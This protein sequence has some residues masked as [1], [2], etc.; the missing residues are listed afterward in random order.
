MHPLEPTDAV[1]PP[2]L[3]VLSR[4]AGSGV[5]IQAATLYLASLAPGA[6]RE[7][8]RAALNA[9]ARLLGHT[10]L[11]CPWEVLRYEHVV[12]LRAVLL[13]RLAAATV[14]RYLAA[15]RG[16]AR[17]AWLLDGLSADDHA[18]IRA[19]KPVRSLRLPAGRA[20]APSEIDALFRC[21]AEDESAAGA[22][23][24]AA[25]GLLFGAGL[26]RGEAVGAQLEAFS[27]DSG[28]LAILG[29][30][31][32]ERA[33]WISGGARRAVDDW[34]SYRG[35]DVPGPLLAPV[36]RHGR[37]HAGK[38]MSAQA[39]VQRLEKRACQARIG[40]CTPH[41]LRRTFVSVALESGADLARVQRLAGHASPRT[42]SRY[43]R[44][45]E[46]ADRAAAERI[47]V[48][49]RRTT[50]GNHKDVK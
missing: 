28:R 29:K 26:R 43:D 3:P 38:S 20:L 10:A 37:V 18:R 49:Y 6:S 22:R 25:F 17:E 23:D 4:T 50:P 45:P 40:P 32:R 9:V 33:V 15:V 41:D 39:L 36:T 48:P 14:N 31:A 34:L 11:T 12:A 24:G 42:T 16:V 13:E 46:A 8:M 30:G 19:V 35:T 44:R 27:P 7:S 1:E 2:A 5:G 21:C 47:H